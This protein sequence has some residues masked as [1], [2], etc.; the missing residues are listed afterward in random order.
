MTQMFLERSFDPP[1]SKQGVLDLAID[2]AG[3]FGI[4]RVDWHRSLLSTDGRKLVCWFSAPDIESARIALRTVNS[5]VR[6]LW[7]GAVHDA[8]GLGKGDV[9]SANVLVERSFEDRVEL[10]D[11]QDIEDAGAW[12]LDTYNVRFLRTYFS[13]DRKRMICL[14][15]AP[16]AES[17]RQAQREAGVP[18]NEAWAYIAVGPEDL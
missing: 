18:F 13:T 12:C 7:S 16:D 2:A 4:H 5:D 15:E 11:I 10:Q 14:Y 8:P 1:L 3:C 9:R 6:R 17:V